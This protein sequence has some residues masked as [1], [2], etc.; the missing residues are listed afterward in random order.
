MKKVTNKLLW[1]FA[2]GQLGWSML[3]GVVVNWLVFF[4]QPAQEVIDK[5]LGIYVKQGPILLGLTL[6]GIIGA[7]GRIF[8]A[9]TDPLI[10]SASDRCRHKDGRRIPFMRAIAVPFGLIT[11]GVFWSPVNGESS[12]NGAVLLVMCLLFYL[13]M[14]IYCTPYNALIPEL[15]KTQKDRI[16]VSTYISATFFVGSAVAYLVPNIAGL[17]TPG[18]SYAAAFRI[19]VT[20]ISVFAT[21]CML[22]PA[23]LIREKDY[24]DSVPSDTPAFSSLAKTFKNKEFRIFVRSDVSYWIALTVFQT[25]LSFYIV[26]LMKLEESMTF[27]LFALMTFISFVCYLPVNL[28]AKKFGKKPLVLFAFFMFAAV[29]LITSQSGKF[30]ISGMIWGLIVAVLAAVPMAILGILQQAIV[31]D[32]AEYDGIA[33]GE[34]REGMFFAARTFAFKLGQSIGMLIFTSVAE[35]NRVTGLGYRLTVV[36]AAIF[37][38]FGGIA[39]LQYNEKK[40]LHLL[41]EQ[42]EKLTG[43]K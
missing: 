1:I 39:L 16:N 30:G 34:K 21:I 5:G 36:I 38:F 4:Y 8:D 29:M 23:L 43:K 42:K 33:T 7:L 32:I 37:C 22:V 6:I 27:I 18:M 24:V 14:T 13:F 15:G 9:V 40:I 11:I 35:I 19:A 20:I 12:V 3:S 25:G 26:S 28:L 10:G 17:F 31:A 2:I 41:G